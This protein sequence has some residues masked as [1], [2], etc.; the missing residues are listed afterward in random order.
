MQATV[1]CTFYF[2]PCFFSVSSV[3]DQSFPIQLYSAA[4]GQMS[5]QPG[6]NPF[7]LSQK[8]SISL[9]FLYELFNLQRHVGCSVKQSGTCVRYDQRHMITRRVNS[10]VTNGTPEPVF[11]ID[12]WLFVLQPALV[13]FWNRLNTEYWGEEI[14]FFWAFGGLW[15]LVI[16]NIAIFPFFIYWMW[17][18]PP[19]P[20]SDYVLAAA[21]CH[22]MSD[23]WASHRHIQQFIHNAAAD[24]HK[25]IVFIKQSHT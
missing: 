20:V 15:W 21:S 14:S 6:W 25:W 13:V 17:H 18:D 11:Q 24:I 16:T 3:L 10:L 4:Q 8:K 5:G 9:Y 7:S 23:F 2:S 19:V 22:S 12:S 1:K